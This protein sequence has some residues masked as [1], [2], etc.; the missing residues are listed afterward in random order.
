MKMRKEDVD[1][2]KKAYHIYYEK[3]SCGTLEKEDYVNYLMIVTEINDFYNLNLKKINFA[4]KTLVVN[5]IAAEKIIMLVEK[6]NE[7]HQLSF[8]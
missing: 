5:D 7:G 6:I 4:G 1:R 2:L 8:I 3:C